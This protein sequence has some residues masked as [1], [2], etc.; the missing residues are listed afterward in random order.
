MGGWV[1][2]WNADECGLTLDDYREMTWE[3]DRYMLGQRWKALKALWCPP[4]VDKHRTAGRRD[5]VIVYIANRDEEWTL[6]RGIRATIGLIFNVRPRLDPQTG[7]YVN[8]WRASSMAFW[9]SGPVYGGYAVDVLKLHS[10]FGVELFND[11]ET[12]L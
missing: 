8:G 7:N 10:W 9:D 12:C 4:V 5:G 11:G 1:R 6:W 2:A 3:H